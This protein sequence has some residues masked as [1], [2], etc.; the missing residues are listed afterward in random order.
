[1]LFAL[2]ICVNKKAH[3]THSVHW[4]LSSH[5]SLQKHHPFYFAKPPLRSAN[6][7]SSPF[8]AIHPQ[9]IGFSFTS[10]KADFSANSHNIK[11]F[12]P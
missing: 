8:E 12:H 2:G 6:Y 1:M 9:Y 10:Q 11:I 3:P 5:S 7:P 4:G